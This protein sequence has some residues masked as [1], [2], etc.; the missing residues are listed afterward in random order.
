[1][2]YSSTLTIENPPLLVA[3]I[4]LELKEPLDDEAIRIA[5]ESAEKLGFSFFE[6]HQF[7]RLMDNRVSRAV[8]VWASEGKSR[9]V[10]FAK[11]EFYFVAAKPRFEDLFHDFSTVLRSLDGKH[12]VSELSLSYYNAFES[13]GATTNLLLSSFQGPPPTEKHEH[14]FFFLMREKDDTW[15]KTKVEFLHGDSY[16]P[17][18][19]DRK[20]GLERY[21]ALQPPFK[22][23]YNVD[24]YGLKLEVIK[25]DVQIKQCDDYVISFKSSIDKMFLE[26][27]TEEAREAWKIKQ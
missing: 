5:K 6:Q 24:C 9:L 1:M 21:L 14:R 27:V 23:E 16:R 25:E 7:A 26:A 15:Y 2:K 19:R 3:W 20:N 8:D 10:C 22:P 11:N 17:D 4:A 13:G 12:P 18:I